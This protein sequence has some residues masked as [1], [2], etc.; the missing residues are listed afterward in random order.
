VRQHEAPL[1]GPGAVLVRVEATSLNYRDLMILRGQYSKAGEGLIPLSDGAGVVVAAGAR[2]ERWRE[3]DR[4]APSFF[5]TWI[6]GPFRE[7]Y[8]PSALG[9]GDTDG[10]LA[11]FIA[12]PE[13]SLVRITDSLTLEEA[14]TLPCAAVTAWQALVVRGHLTADDIV[15]VQ[16]TGGVA[17]FALQI[18]NALGAKVIVTTSSEE[19]RARAVQ[20]GAWATINY[21]T[22]PE[23]DVEVRKLTGGIGVSHVVELGGPATYERSIRALAAGGKISQIG[24]LTGWGPQPNLSRLQAINADINGISV[25]SAEQFAALNEF[26][27][28]HQIRPV[29]DRVFRFDEAE[30][31]YEYLASGRHFGKVVIK[32]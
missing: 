32:L 13:E 21:Q 23:W 14:A 4:V 31:A 29:I 5:R 28:A 9:G 27:V 18:A 24:V 25:G 7:A 22:T 3:G 1:P 17:I 8:R 6:D 16:G 2:V 26:L 12:M 19:K 10:V 11:N 15:L 30:A 20:L